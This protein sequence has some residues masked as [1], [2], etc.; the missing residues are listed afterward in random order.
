MCWKPG[1][2]GRKS[3]RRDN[4]TPEEQKAL[5]TLRRKDIVIKKADKGSS[6]VVMLHEDYVCKVIQHLDNA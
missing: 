6:V 1:A 4:L 2:Q 3:Y 5:Q